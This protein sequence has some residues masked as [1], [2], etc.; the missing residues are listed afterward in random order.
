M[1]SL[2]EWREAHTTT[3]THVTYNTAQVVQV[4]SRVS[5]LAR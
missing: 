3:S 4:V 1:N 2:Y 5:D